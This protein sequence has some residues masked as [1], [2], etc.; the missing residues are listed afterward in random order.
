MK[1]VLNGL[2]AA[3]TIAVLLAGMLFALL[4]PVT[5][6]QYENRPAVALPRFSISSAA[7]GAFQD[8][9]ES[10]LH[11]QLPGA[12]VLEQT[13]QSGL[14]AIILD[15]VFA[16]SRAR[17]DAYYQFND[18]ML[19]HGDIVYAP[20]Y[21][22]S[23]MSELLPRI[24]NIN[25]ALAAHPQ[26]RFYVLYIE[27]DT[28]LDFETGTHT[29]VA[30]VLRTHLWLPQSHIDVYSVDS[31]DDFRSNF[32][33]TDH[34]WNRI[35]SYAGYLQ[36]LDLL[37]KTDPLTP[38][39][40]RHMSDDFCGAKAI[41]SGAAAY[42]SE[43]FDVY[44]FDFPPMDIYVNGVGPADYGRQNIE[45]DDEEF[46]PVSYGGFYGFDYGEV[47]FHTKNEG[48]GNLLIIGDSFD[49]AIL[50]LL[51]GHFENLYAVDLRAYEEDTG[52]AFSFSRYLSAHRIDT[53]LFMGNID[54]FLLDSFN[55][56]G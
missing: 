3:G 34:H 27:K 19:Y 6:N 43:P 32:Y 7:A 41:S 46:G 51:A 49:N 36:V 50:K 33:R 14:S 56:E 25:T 18:L 23:S 44:T 2:M 40:T 38:T 20:M 9:L 16:Q 1:K 21:A 39:D 5:E 30:D 8:E 13:Y 10:A 11:D 35:G 12:M 37:G 15:A 29:G 4:Q 52:K 45:W 42:F 54:Y 28:D 26:L 31:F 24:A 47:A 53:V 17:P 55:V 48:A 22:D